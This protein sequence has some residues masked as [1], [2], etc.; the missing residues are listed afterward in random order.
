MIVVV[1][2][3]FPDFCV[4]SSILVTSSSVNFENTFQDTHSERTHTAVAYASHLQYI[5]SD[6]GLSNGSW[7]AKKRMMQ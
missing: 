2:N 7:G 4:A 5:P 6:A 1:W 3:T